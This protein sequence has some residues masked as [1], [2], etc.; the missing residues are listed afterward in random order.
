MPSHS[1]SVRRRPIALASTIAALLACNFA[2][3]AANKTWDGGSGVDSAWLTAANWDLDAAPVSNDALIFAGATRLGPVNDFAANGLFNGI[4]FNAGAGAFTLSGNAI[5]LTTGLTGAAGAVTG[6]N[7][8]NNSTST[9]TVNLPVTFGA[10]NHTF[11]TA[12]SSGAL[13]FSGALT[14]AANATAVFTKNG[15]NINFAGSGLANDASGILG[16]WAVIGND[17]ATLDGGGNI[18]AYAAYTPIAAGAITSGAT[19]NYKYS[20]E[21]ANLTV[22]DGTTINSLVTTI[23]AARSLTITGTMRLGTKGGIYRTGASTANSVMTV[24]GGTLTANGGGE[25]TLAC[26]TN[27]AAN[28]AATNNNLSVASVIAND[29][30][31]AV[32]VNVIGYVVMSGAN[33]FTGGTFINQGR[34]QASNVSAFGVGGVVTVN[35][36]A[37]A[38]LNNNGTFANPFVIA[39]I[40]ATEASGGQQLGAVSGGVAISGGGKL[41]AAAKI[42]SARVFTLG[43]GGGTIDTNGNDVTLDANST[44]TGTTL[45]KIGSG[46]LTLAGIQTYATLNANGGTTHVESALGT[47]TSTVNVGAHLDFTVSQTLAALN[48]A[49]GAVATFGPAT[50]PA[51]APDLLAAAA[52]PEPGSLGLLMLGALGILGRRPPR[53]N[54][55]AIAGRV[56]YGPT[57]TR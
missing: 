7:A 39:G 35:P 38:F 56:S 4:T 23:S 13:N 30:G 57:F 42:T 48:I 37:E 10:G 54:V 49:D 25:I 52:V 6:G 32:S 34:V 16:G 14:R 31:N 53:G 17:F 24:T 50:S 26:A 12:A 55:N 19:F 33:T 3:R 11:V 44:V 9:E 36:G 2:A 5:T 18:A 28:F 27:T 29:G 8:T 20:A 21:S 45:T 47:G 41:Q 40:G 22:A 1:S 15:G 43:A 51:P 46:A